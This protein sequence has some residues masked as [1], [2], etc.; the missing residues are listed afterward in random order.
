MREREEARGED[1]DWGRRQSRTAPSPFGTVSLLPASSG[2]YSAALYSKRFGVPV[3]L[4]VIT[5]A[6]ALFTSH[7]RIVL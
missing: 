5:F 6:V 3:G 4:P 7:V 2:L 1:T